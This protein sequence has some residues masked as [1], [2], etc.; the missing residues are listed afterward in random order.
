MANDARQ[1]ALALW[2]QNR[3]RC[4]WFMRDDFVPSSKDDFIRCLHTLA[5]HGDRA[6]YVMARKLMKCL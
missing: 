4:A 6:T 3:A 5:Q 2:E 1:Q